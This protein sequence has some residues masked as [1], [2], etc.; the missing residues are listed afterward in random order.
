MGGEGSGRKPDPVKAFMKQTAMPVNPQVCNAMVLPNFSGLKQEVKKT[1]SAILITN[2]NIGSYVTP[3]TDP[4]SLHL[5]Q[6]TPQSVINGT[7]IFV[8]GIKPYSS[9]SNYFKI[10]GNTLAM[11]YYV[12]TTQKAKWEL[13]GNSIRMGM[14]DSSET[15]AQT[16]LYPALLVNNE[17]HLGMAT[18]PLLKLSHYG[19]DDD[20]FDYFRKTILEADYTNGVKI[21]D[22]YALPKV[23]G[24]TGQALKT[25]G[26]GNCSWGTF[27]TAEADTLQSVTTRGATTSTESTFS[28]GIIT[29]EIHPSADS[30]TALQIRKADGTTTVATVDTTNSRLGVGVTPSYKFDVSGDTRLA[31]MVGIGTSN[32]GTFTLNIGSAAYATLR[33]LGATA[34]DFRF[35]HSGAGTNVKEVLQRTQNGT[36]SWSSLTDAGGFNKQNILVLDHATG[37]VGIGTTPSTKIHSLSTTEQL[38]LGYDASHYLSFT[39]GSAN[40]V[41]LANAVAADI[42]IN[43]G[44]DKTLVL[45]ETVWQDVQFQVS[46]GRVAAANFPDWDSAFTTNTGEYKFDV[47]DYIDLAANE[48]PHNW[49]EG[50]TIK[51]HLHL[52]LDGANSS[53]SN[54]YAK[55]T[56][57]IAYAD[58]N[59]VWTETSQTAELTIPTGTADLTHLL[60]SMG[61]LAFT[62]QLIGTQ[63]KVRVKRIA[64][65]GGTEY[66]NHIFI[67]QYGIHYE[68]D[69]LGSRTVTSK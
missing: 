30:T 51:P 69:T 66:P 9:G 17:S 32:P 14:A 10:G 64:A 38:R 25:D 26:A 15:D 36:T 40:A 47:D 20:L 61:D 65:T 57:Y 22:T 29:P 33:V 24:S 44:T 28:G 54:Q 4:L 63:I 59:E 21:W 43:C 19:W 58:I 8:G 37:N 52:A 1:D 50:T 23:D 3:E 11:T 34:A 27:L 55:F 62:N 2:E 45:T 7:P 5:D 31:G 67:T 46:S 49:K 35:S 60:L 13:L 6:T 56:V 18:K 16:E 68:I 41:T 53:G 39:V 42:N 12:G 48:M